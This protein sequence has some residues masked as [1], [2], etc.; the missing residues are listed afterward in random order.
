M[1]KSTYSAVLQHF[2]S[3]QNAF[4][5]EKDLIAIGGST[6]IT[7]FARKFDVRFER[8]IGDIDISVSPLATNF[9]EWCRATQKLSPVEGVGYGEYS[10]AEE[11]VAIL[12]ESNVQEHIRFQWGG[13]KF[14][15]FVSASHEC[16]QNVSTNVQIDSSMRDGTRYVKLPYIRFVK[17]LYLQH[18]WAYGATSTPKH[19]QDLA[20]IDLIIKKFQQLK[21]ELDALQAA[22]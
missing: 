1:N 22:F 14:C 13:K 19:T 5:A 4:A 12:K 3:L 18:S 8:G 21:A 6:V 16:F 9:I 10:G 11:Y 15:I 20:T 17:G 2:Y 7:A